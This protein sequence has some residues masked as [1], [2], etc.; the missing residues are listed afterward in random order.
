MR[1]RTTRL[2]EATLCPRANRFRRSVAVILLLLVTY[3]VTA[4]LVHR[5]GQLLL[6]NVVP[7]AAVSQSQTTDP[8]A[9]L[10]SAGSICLLC[11]FQQQLALGL[12]HAPRFAYRPLVLTMTA[13]AFSSRYLS[14]PSSPPRGRGPPLA[15]LV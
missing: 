6:P 4:E 8:S 7:S 3:N 2:I 14:A 11:Q 5:H 9:R 1:Q 12:I 15:S 13:G 10:T